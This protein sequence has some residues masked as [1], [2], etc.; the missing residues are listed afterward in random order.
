MQKHYL[1]KDYYEINAPKFIKDPLT[2]SMME[3]LK[4]NPTKND[5]KSLRKF[6]ER[7]ME[8]LNIKEDLRAKKLISKMLRKTN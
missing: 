4:D 3:Y 8:I 6:K 1:D 7:T 5:E 2:R